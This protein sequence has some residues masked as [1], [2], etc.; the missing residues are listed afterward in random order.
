MIPVYIRDIRI[1]A[2]P[3]GITVVKNI[4][5]SRFLLPPPQ[6]VRAEGS[7][8]SGHVQRVYQAFVYQ[9]PAIKNLPEP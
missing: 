6:H 9:M 5:G 3:A 4:L 1:S 7:P 2:V 8:T